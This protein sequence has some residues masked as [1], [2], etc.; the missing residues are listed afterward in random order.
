MKYV[1]L[2]FLILL[3]SFSMRAGSF[4]N[5]AEFYALLGTKAT[6]SDLVDAVFI[7]ES[8]GMNKE[9]AASMSALGFKGI[10]CCETESEKI[11]VIYRARELR[12]AYKRDVAKLRKDSYKQKLPDKMKLV[13]IEKFVPPTI[14]EWAK[15]DLGTNALQTICA[16]IL[17]F[18]D[19]LDFLIRETGPDS[20][21][22]HSVLHRNI[23][24]FSKLTDDEKIV[25]LYRAQIAMIK[26]EAENA[27]R[28]V[29]RTSVP[30]K[31]EN[32]RPPVKPYRSYKRHYHI[33]PAKTKTSSL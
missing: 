6:S 19:F 29:H 16:K 1:I 22:P 5:S 3:T 17:D 32:G 2:S 25:W 10:P 12:R 14:E 23:G 20:I 9:R 31:N 8:N 11:Q 30:L 18:N 13:A 7:Y 26:I 4:Y 28:D 27:K 21:K 33:G 15:S 24:S